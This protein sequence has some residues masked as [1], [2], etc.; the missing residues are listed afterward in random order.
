MTL[1][2][3]FNEELG[4]VIQVRHDESSDVMNVLREFDLGACSHIIGKVNERGVIEFTRDA[5]VIYSKRRSE[6]HRLWSETSW[7]IARLRD[8]PACVDQEYERLLDETDP[9]IT[10]KLTHDTSVNV[11]APFIATARVRAWR[12]C[13]SRASTRT[14]KPRGRC[15]RPA[16]R[17]STCT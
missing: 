4:A 17:R 5:K 9:G 12:S 7:R 8:N 15:T 10:P 6:L 11:A 2:A 16:S 1:R 14:S 3:L 13:A